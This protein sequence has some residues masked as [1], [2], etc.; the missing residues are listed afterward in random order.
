MWDVSIRDCYHKL[1][2]KNHKVGDPE[3]YLEFLKQSQKIIKAILSKESEENL[4]KKH[5]K[6]LDKILSVEFDL[7]ILPFWGVMSKYRKIFGHKKY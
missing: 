5:L 2:T 1:H 3:C 4:W 6:F 7:L